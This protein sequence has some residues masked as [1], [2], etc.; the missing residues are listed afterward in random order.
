MSLNKKRKVIRHDGRGLT[1]NKI[2]AQLD[3]GVSTTY[4][5]L[6]TDNPNFVYKKEEESNWF[7]TLTESVSTY[8]G[9]QSSYM[10]TIE[11]LKGYFLC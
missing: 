5:T 3:S 1:S 8:M 7:N 4:V 2:K 11:V 6:V 9:R 10:E